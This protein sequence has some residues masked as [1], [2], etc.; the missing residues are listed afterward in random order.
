MIIKIGEQF[1]DSQ[2]VPMAILLSTKDK[3]NIAKLPGGQDVYIS[4]PATSDLN[5]IIKWSKRGWQGSHTLIAGEGS[6]ILVPSQG[7]GWR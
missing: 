2:T 1:Y 6:K 3:A 5:E 4:C 7:G